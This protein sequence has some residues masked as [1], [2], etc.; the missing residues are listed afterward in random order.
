MVAVVCTVHQHIFIHNRLV[1]GGIGASAGAAFRSLIAVNKEL[2]VGRIKTCLNPHGTPRRPVEGSRERRTCGFP[3]LR[4]GAR[5][6]SERGVW[7]RVCFVTPFGQGVVSRQTRTGLHAPLRRR[8]GRQTG[9]HSAGLSVIR[10]S[11]PT[12]KQ[13]PDTLGTGAPVHIVLLSEEMMKMLTRNVGFPFRT[14]KPFRAGTD[15]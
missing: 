12:C 8:G 6:R 3:P 10:V 9:T 11:H 13:L 2:L 4:T 14:K 1:A 7:F 5:Q 15:E